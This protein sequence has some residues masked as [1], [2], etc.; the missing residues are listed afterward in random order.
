MLDHLKPTRLHVAAKVI[1]MVQAVNY[2]NKTHAGKVAPREVDRIYGHHK[3]LSIT[4][5]E[6]SFPH[7]FPM[8]ST[9][10]QLKLVCGTAVRRSLWALETICLPASGEVMDIRE[11]RGMEHA[12]EIWMPVMVGGTWSNP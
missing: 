7:L 2:K 5:W 10:S 9:L 6:E 8:L 1:P 11:S 4:S 12:V 3:H